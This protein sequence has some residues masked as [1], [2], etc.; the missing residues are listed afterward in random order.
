VKNENSTTRKQACNKSV[1]NHGEVALT[2]SE[3]IQ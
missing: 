1:T 3:P 2:E